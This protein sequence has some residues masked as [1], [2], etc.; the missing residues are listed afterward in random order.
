MMKL[1]TVARL[2]EEYMRVDFQEELVQ[3]IRE[4]I[5]NMNQKALINKFVLRTFEELPCTHEYV[6]LANSGLTNNF[7]YESKVGSVDIYG[8]KVNYGPQELVNYTEDLI[9][10]DF[11]KGKD[12]IAQTINYVKKS[13]LY[14]DL[15][16]KTCYFVLSSNSITDGTNVISDKNQVRSI[17][18]KCTLYKGYSW[19]NSEERNLRATLVNASKYSAKERLDKLDKQ[20]GGSLKYWMNKSL[21]FKAIQKLATRNGLQNPGALFIGE[22]G[23]EEWGALFLTK[24]ISGNSDTTDE[25][26]K[27]L[28]ERGIELDDYIID[29]QHIKNAAWLVDVL[30]KH[31]NIETTEDVVAGIMEQERSVGAGNK[32]AGCYEYAD[33]FELIVK[34]LKAN[35]QYKIIGNPKKI[36]VIHDVNSSKIP[37]YDGGNYRSMILDI[38]TA[39]AHAVTSGQ[40]L[41]KLMYIDKDRTVN[42]L[43]NK[44]YNN[45]VDMTDITTEDSE[46]TSTGSISQVLFGL[47]PEMASTDLYAL[48]ALGKDIMKYAKGAITKTRVK[49]KGSN[50]RAQFDNSFMLIGNKESRILS[51]TKEGYIEC[52]NAD[53]IAKNRREIKRVEKQYKKDL[54]T[55]SLADAR[56]K[57]RLALNEFMV[58]LALKYPC[59][60]N[61]EFEMFRFVTKQEIEERCFESG[62]DTQVADKL[63]RYFTTKSAGCIVIA[64]ENILKH[65]LAGMDTDFDGLTV[66]LEKELVDIASTAYTTGTITGD[67][68]IPSFTVIL[69]K[70]KEES[71]NFNIVEN[72]ISLKYR[73]DFS[74]ELSIIKQLNNIN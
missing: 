73:Q 42:F 65:K 33:V 27:Y 39:S 70:I 66:I 1:N 57:R 18:S 13:G 7:E 9:S 14:V 28:E 62:L 41:S 12:N 5:Y 23:N 74:K 47:N 67:S 63:Y 2:N 22:F 69:N 37:N 15:K 17:L 52:Y 34:Y 11:G 72:C 49:I 31:H 71:K 45:L 35:Y 16:E 54:Q 51:T 53:V 4:G 21:D 8:I 6:V 44:L 46:Y 26:G 43:Y 19:S 55:M 25:Y 50:Y 60:G 56:E 24:K 58:G 36:A 20:L 61:S 30:Y 32:S 40:S 38:A 59:P 29:G 48:T 64:P 10:V 68:T 3:I